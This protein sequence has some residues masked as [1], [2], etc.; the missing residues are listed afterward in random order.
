M[1]FSHFDSYDSCEYSNCSENSQLK[2]FY[3]QK[4][5]FAQRAKSI[6]GW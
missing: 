2:I 5:L 3:P 4:N 6:D 1:K